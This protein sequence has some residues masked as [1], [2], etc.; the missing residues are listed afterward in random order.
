MEGWAIKTKQRADLGK[1]GEAGSLLKIIDLQ[2]RRL[3]WRGGGL[4]HLPELEEVKILKYKISEARAAV[5]QS[6]SAITNVTELPKQEGKKPAEVAA[7]KKQEAKYL[8]NIGKNTAI[9]IQLLKEA[10]EIVSA[11]PWISPSTYIK[12]ENRNVLLQLLRKEGFFKTLDQKV[13]WEL[14]KKIDIRRVSLH[15]VN[16][17]GADLSSLVLNGADFEGANLKEA[18]LKGTHLFRANLT[19]TN[20]VDAS[21]EGAFLEGANFFRSNLV[22]TKLNNVHADHVNFSH[23]DLRSANLDGGLLKHANFNNARLNSATLQAADLEFSLMIRTDLENA[24]LSA[25]VLNNAILT[26]AFLK[27]AK[28]VKAF[29]WSVTLNGANVEGADF[30]QAL[31]LHKEQFDL[32]KNSA[33]AKNVKFNQLNNF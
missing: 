24:N 7:I 8:E 1:Y 13:R 11:E 18:N 33:E 4:K 26:S 20:L 23:A 5:Q 31:G 14:V 9:G 15:E 12:P 16:L 21:L 22:R 27:N 29:M 25:A 32:T 19:I 2:G 17:V 6:I 10:R 30:K 3:E 28:F